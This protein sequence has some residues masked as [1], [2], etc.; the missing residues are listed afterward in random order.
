MKILVVDD[1]VFMR[2][3]LVTILEKAGHK[4]VGQASDGNEGYDLF[5]ELRPDLVTM[6]ITM[7]NCNGI[8][9]LIKIK[10]LDPNAKVL[11]CSAVG[12]REKVLESLKHGAVNFIVKPFKAKRVLE[13]I[14][15]IKP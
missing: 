8:E 14:D 2:N 13:I 1:A 6:D 9:C 5:K 15:I 10:E 4:V 11:M 12:Q 3:T 7:P